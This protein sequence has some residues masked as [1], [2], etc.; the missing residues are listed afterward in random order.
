[1]IPSQPN[2]REGDWPTC[3]KNRQRS[4][5]FLDRVRVMDSR[6]DFTNSPS[7]NCRAFA[8]WKG[9]A[10]ASLCEPSLV[11]RLSRKKTNKRHRPRRWTKQAGGMLQSGITRRFVTDN[12][13][14]GQGLARGFLHH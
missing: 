7:H 4:F 9:E 13:L 5:F 11:A 6:R 3:D 12:P 8:G 10:A 1:M 2:F 14:A